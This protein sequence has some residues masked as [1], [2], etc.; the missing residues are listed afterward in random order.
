MRATMQKY[1]VMLLSAVLMLLGMTLLPAGAAEIRLYDEGSKLS[2]SEVTE[3]EARLRQASE[4]TGMNIGVI[5]GVQNR[6]D[7]T[8]EATAK[9]SYTELFGAR[10]NGLVYYMDLKGYNPY[11]YIATSGLGQFYYTNGAPDRVSEMYDQLDDYLYPIGSENVYDAILRFAE[12]VEYYYDKG[13]PE[14]YCVYDDQDRMYY[15]VSD[16]HLV[17]T[18]TKP[19]RNPAI[20]VLFASIGAVIGLLAALCTFAAVKGAYK[21]KY[22]LSP[23]TYT[24]KK[25]VEYREQYDNFTHT[26]T[27]R[28][29]I[30]S[31]G[32]RS[33]GG[34]S[35]IGHSSGGFGGGGHH[36]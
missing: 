5:I 2:P 27:S 19:F 20:I 12:L 28:V 22:E 34:H 9:A 30:E 36:R 32:S 24:N 26:S 3:I 16:G 35:S 25:N 8:I 33:G 29:H 7:L 21:F 13:V 17:A 15:H 11:D 4:N 14:Y 31:S 10:T 23:T 18:N 1:I 6:S